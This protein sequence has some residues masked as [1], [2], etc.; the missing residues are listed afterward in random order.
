MKKT[1]A[2]ITAALLLFLSAVSVF[3]GDGVYANA[4]ELY[5]AWYEDLPDSICGVWSTDGGTASLTFGIQDTEE[6]N[7]LKREMLDLIRDDTTVT[8]VYQKYSRNYLLRIQEEL[9]EYFRRDA[10]LQSSA[11][12]ETDNRIDLGIYE[13]R[14]DDAATLEMIAELKEKYG[15]AVAFEYTGELVASIDILQTKADYPTRYLIFATA[16]AVLILGS[17]LAFA[18]RR[19]R[20]AVLQTAHGEAVTVSA[21]LTLKEVEALVRETDVTVPARIDTKVAEAIERIG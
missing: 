21:S 11:L 4:G 16:A 19:R 7:A 10:G 13:K 8:F 1:V 2:L 3:A 15:D 9:Y 18:V 12:N 14:K 17:A 20:T 5:E 6:G